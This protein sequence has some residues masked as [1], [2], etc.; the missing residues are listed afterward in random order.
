MTHLF[1]IIHLRCMSICICNCSTSNYQ[2]ITWIDLSTFELVFDE[3]LWGPFVGLWEFLIE[4]SL[5]MV[6]SAFHFMLNF[7][8]LEIL[9]SC[10]YLLFILKNVLIQGLRLISKFM[11]SQTGQ[12]IFTIYILPYISKSKVNQEIKFT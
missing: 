10:F 4:N 1:I 6:K 8:F 5:K 7:L 9:H 11:M 3:M 2:T 12:K